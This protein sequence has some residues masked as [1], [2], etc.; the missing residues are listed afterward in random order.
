MRS[1]EF[2]YSHAVAHGT[3]GY[4]RPRGLFLEGDTTQS[5]TE[6]TIADE[7][8]ADESSGDESGVDG[9]STTKTS[10]DGSSLVDLYEKKVLVEDNFERIVDQILASKTHIS[11]LSC[12]IC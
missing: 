1:I 5:F 10:M 12:V 2:A 6:S 9:P 4:C 7:S 3:I 11:T 8:S